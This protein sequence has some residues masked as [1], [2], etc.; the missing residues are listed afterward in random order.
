[1]EGQPH[2]D[3]EQQSVPAENTVAE[4]QRFKTLGV[5]IEEG[6]H[7]Q[8]S[9]IAQLSG[10][11][12]A[13]E[14]KGSIEARVRSAQDDPDLVARA[15]AVQAELQR[16][17]EAKRQAIAGFFGRAAVSETVEQPAAPKRASGRRKTA[18]SDVTE[19]A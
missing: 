4:Q 15:E 9:F 19:Q 1:M 18:G 12:L 14:I 7:A 16:E 5:R 8:L 11:T 3:N 13:D 2:N 6:L 17:A 10:N